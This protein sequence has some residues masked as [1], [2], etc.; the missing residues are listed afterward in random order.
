MNIASLSHFTPDPIQ[1]SHIVG[2]IGLGFVG[3]AIVEFLKSNQYTLHKT[4]FTFDK[5]KRTD[6]NTSSSL[7]DLLRCDF[8]F[9]CLPTQY[10]ITNATYCLDAIHETLQYFSKETYSGLLI[11][12][13]TVLPGTTEN[14]SI[15]YN[16]NLIH[17]PEFLTARTAN[18]DFANQSH[19]VLGTTN[20]ISENIL[21]QSGI[22]TFINSNWPSISLSICTSK[23]SESMKLFLNSFYAIK[24]QFFTELYVLCN[25]MQ[26]DYNIVKQMMLN[27]NWI[28][29]M[30]TNIP[31]PDGQISYGGLCFP[32]DTMALESFMKNLESPSSILTATINERNQMRSDKDNLI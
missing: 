11:L 14:L 31:G 22:H 19:M 26:I 9:L 30:H 20:K 6:N 25:K 27:N 32:K 1:K 10:D 29:P 8:I 28:N 4:I 3:T 16:L 5:Y 21:E 18:V 24:V 15:Q 12:K 2:V 7:N 23:E 13:S 17:N